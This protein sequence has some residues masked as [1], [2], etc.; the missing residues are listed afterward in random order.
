MKTIV[1]QRGKRSKYG[2]FGEM[3]E[4]DVNICASL[5]RPWFNNA[6]NV[7]CIPAGSYKC[8]VETSNRFPYL[9][10]RLHNVEGRKDILIHKGN[11]IIDSLGCIL[12]GLKA[13]T[14]G[15]DKS[16]LALDKLL[17]KYPTGFTLVIKD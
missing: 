13:N 16:K 7:S 12:V 9:H 14:I 8:T 6:E 4:A 3:H 2:V 17:E 1:L 10:Y 11:W 15:L 5:E